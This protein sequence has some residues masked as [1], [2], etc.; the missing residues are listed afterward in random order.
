MKRNDTSI[1]GTVVFLI[2]E[3][4]LS[5]DLYSFMRAWLG[6]VKIKKSGAESKKKQ[7][8]SGIQNGH[9]ICMTVLPPS[10][11]CSCFLGAY[12]NPISTPLACL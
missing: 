2:K 5:L 7:P 6:G 12:F 10:R 8:I 3:L 9:K 1:I 4:E 11:P